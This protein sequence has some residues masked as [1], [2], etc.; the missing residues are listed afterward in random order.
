MKK[1]WVGRSSEAIAHVLIWGFC[2]FPV[3]RDL[4][5]R[6]EGLEHVPSR[7]PVVIAARH[8][9]NFYDGAILLTR[10]RYPVHLLVALDWTRT[11][12][13]RRLLETMCYVARWPGVLRA[14]AWN[15]GR[16]QY[17]GRSAY[18]LS[19]ASACLRRA[20]ATAVDVLR[21]GDILVVFPEAYPNIDP[22]A[23]PKTAP[24]EF[25]PFELGFAKIAQ[26]AERD[27]HARVAILPAGFTYAPK[28][29][30]QRRQQVTLRLGEP[31]TLAD[32]PDRQRLAATIEQQVKK[33][34]LT[35]AACQRGRR[36]DG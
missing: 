22:D 20:L 29:P 32:Y 18:Q 23:T 4:D 9:H 30:G 33:L 12:L 28:Q 11:P 10:L 14:D 34:S 13:Q 27:G 36:P 35:P 26:M 7:G 5:V 31:I 19:E 2:A 8:Y 3:W 25:L 1:S 17:D 24:D 15:I 16:G 21:S 6:I